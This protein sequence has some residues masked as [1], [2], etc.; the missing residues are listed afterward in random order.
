ML[1][2]HTSANSIQS[3]DALFAICKPLLAELLRGVPPEDVR[4]VGVQVSKLRYRWD[5]STTDSFAEEESAKQ[6]SLQRHFSRPADKPAIDVDRPSCDTVS[7]TAASSVSSKVTRV[8][9]PPKRSNSGD[10]TP[11]SWV[12]PTHIDESVLAVMPSPLRAEIEQEISRRRQQGYGVEEKAYAS[13]NA[14]TRDK[15]ARNLSS[16]F[17]PRTTM[18]SSDDLRTC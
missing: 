15:G 16:V 7:Y 17:L 10:T 5:R 12:I 9:E 3:H 4:G 6:T 13:H 18:A 11:G 8:S 14:S 1:R 2:S